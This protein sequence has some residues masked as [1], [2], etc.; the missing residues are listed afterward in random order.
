MAQFE[1]AIFW[2]EGM[3]DRISPIRETNAQAIALARRLLHEARHGALAFTDPQ[4][5]APSVS[6][7]AV[8]TDADGA[9]LLFISELARHTWALK[10]DPRCAL[11][12]GEPGKGDPLA[13]P[14]VTL[15][16]SARKL[17]RESAEFSALSA[18]FLAH[19]PKAALYIGLTDFSFFRLEILSAD[20]N[21]G[22]G[23]AYKLDGADFL[24]N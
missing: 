11:M 6:R 19:Q 21:G 14:R 18:R 4:T 7:V 23:R 17:Q 1:T 8:A 3:T 16:C 13:H 5:G 24:L 22:F 12:A 15:S 10:R 2:R 9:P 20:L